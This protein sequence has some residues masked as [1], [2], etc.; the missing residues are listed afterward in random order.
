LEASSAASDSTEDQAYTMG[1][2]FDSIVK[3]DIITFSF[4]INSLCDQRYFLQFD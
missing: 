1:V 3:L 4:I 2:D